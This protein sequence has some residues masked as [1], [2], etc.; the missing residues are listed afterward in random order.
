MRKEY[1]LLGWIGN[2]GFKLGSLVFIPLRCSSQGIFIF[3]QTVACL[4]GMLPVLCFYVTQ[5]GLP[6]WF[7]APV[8]PSCCC[9]HVASRQQ[10]T[11]HVLCILMSSAGFLSFSDW[12]MCTPI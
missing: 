2:D 3:F 12:P 11:D 9:R 8:C 10:L 1:S 6:M 5:D 4:D 7:M